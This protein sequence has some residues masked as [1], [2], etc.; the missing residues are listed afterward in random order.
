MVADVLH[1]MNVVTHSHAFQGIITGVGTAAHIDYQAFVTQKSW[2]DL[3]RYRWGLATFRWFQGAVIGA[4]SG[5]ILGNYL[6]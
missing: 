5:S 4:V 1:F 3:I 6:G 2:D